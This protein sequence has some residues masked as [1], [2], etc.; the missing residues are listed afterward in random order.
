MPCCSIGTVK[1]SIV[2][3]ITPLI[4]IMMEQKDKFTAMGISAEY[5]G[6]SQTDHA[7]RTRVVCGEVDLVFI[8]PESIIC[9]PKYRNMLLTPVYRKKLIAVAVDEAHCVKTW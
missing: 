6:E 8:S 2:I 5:V 1:E 4:A 3:C 9:N 7:A